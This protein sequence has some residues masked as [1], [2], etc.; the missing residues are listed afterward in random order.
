MKIRCSA[1]N[2]REH[3]EW[4]DFKVIRIR[5][6]K[7]YS[8][9]QYHGLQLILS[10]M[11]HFVQWKWQTEVYLFVQNYI[12]S[13]S[14]QSRYQEECVAP[15][16]TGSPR[17]PWKHLVKKLCHVRSSHTEIPLFKQQS[18]NGVGGTLSAVTSSL[19]SFTRPLHKGWGTMKSLQ[20]VR[21]M[22]PWWRWLFQIVLWLRKRGLPLSRGQAFCRPLCASERNPSRS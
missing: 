6:S 18:K 12:R 13:T 4:V 9:K 11:C 14:G 2:R 5:S 22:V 15:A 21:V 8:D 16:K 1:K 19:S 17:S 7:S 3:E 20:A 10:K